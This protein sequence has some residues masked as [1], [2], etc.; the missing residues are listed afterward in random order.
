MIRRTAQAVLVLTLTVA[1]SLNAQQAAPAGHPL[2]EIRTVQVQPT[3][4][5]EPDKVKEPQA[6]SL[7]ED[8]LKDA[9][10]QANIQVD[11]N[12]AVSAHVVLDQFSSGGVAERVG[13]GFGSGRSSIGCHLVL[14]DASGRELANVPIHV[15]G[16]KFLSSYEGNGTQRRQAVSSL[17]RKLAQEIE[18]LK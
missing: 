10:R 17:D 14:Q 5:A 13:V 1:F 4:V 9:L 7:V 8:S 2:H 3:V 15:H 12:S 11:D 16:N 6:A 18:K